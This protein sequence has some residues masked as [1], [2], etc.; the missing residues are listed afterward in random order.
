MQLF[1]STVHGVGLVSTQ[2]AQL[3]IYPKVGTIRQTFVSFSRNFFNFISDGK[4]NCGFIDKR[5]TFFGCRTL[6]PP[7][8]QVNTQ[9]DQLIVQFRFLFGGTGQ[10]NN[11][12]LQSILLTQREVRV[13]F[14]LCSKRAFKSSDCISHASAF[15]LIFERYYFFS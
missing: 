15:H 12:I 2:P 4:S 10:F 1:L 9:T 6:S 8:Q 11:C 13:G 7:L 5:C 14:V 3:P